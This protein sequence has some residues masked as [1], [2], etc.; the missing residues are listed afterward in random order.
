MSAGRLEGGL[1][2]C[3]AANPEAEHRSASSEQQKESRHRKDDAAGRSSKEEGK[4]DRKQGDASEEGHEPAHRG[5]PA[6]T[7]AGIWKEL[8]D[9]SKYSG[10]DGE[11]EEHD[12]V[13]GQRL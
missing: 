6:K 7:L 2:L 12:Q 1:N 5:N 13:R 10:S 9:D 3:R 4:H 8:N 11:R